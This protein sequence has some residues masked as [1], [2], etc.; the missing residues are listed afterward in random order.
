MSAFASSH[1]AA[2][3][4]PLLAASDLR[5]D[6]GGAPAL[7]R[8]S[9]EIAGPSAVLVGPGGQALL[10][11]LAGAAEIR[12]GS[13]GVAG[14]DVTTGAHRRKTG[15]APLDPPLFESWE[16]LEYLVWG[17]RL[18]GLSA[19]DARTAAGRTLEKLGLA[20]LS[21]SPIARL[22]TAERRAL[23]LAQAVLT[24]PPVLVASAPLSGLERDA[25]TFLLDVCDRAFDG[26]RWLS[27][28]FDW[29]PDGRERPLLERAAEVLVFS[30]GGLA[31]RGT[32]RSLEAGAGYELAVLGPIEPLAALLAERG[33]VLHGG[34]RRY[35]VDLPPEATSADL[36]SCSIESAT[37]IVELTP[38]FAP[39]AA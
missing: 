36:L 3:A 7:E 19:N 34:P 29:G 2:L 21:R 10:A 28:A 38:R 4:G 18:F 23:V 37:P 27:S 5:V 30:A 31:R 14:S 32:L 1:E 13:L 16:S 24:D 26:R 39:P 11:A 22:S 25:A 6:F 33:I 15:L 35:F 17:G 8:G 20:K 9:F 12:A